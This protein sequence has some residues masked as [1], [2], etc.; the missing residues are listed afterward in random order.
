MHANR[1]KYSLLDYQEK[2]RNG[3]QRLGLICKNI[4]TNKRYI[5]RPV[6]SCP[7]LPEGRKKYF[8]KIYNR[9]KNLL[10]IKK[11][12][13]CTLTYS[14]SL[15]TPEAAALRI[16][17]D[18]DKFF[19][20]LE[21][22]KSKPQYFYVIEV[23]NNLMVHIHI[24]FQGYVHKSK[25]SASWKA[26]TGCTAIRIQGIDYQKALY[27]CF[28]YLTK[29][30]KQNQDKWA[31]IFK[32]IDRIW[33]CSRK[34]FG[35]ATPEAKKW[36]LECFFV[37][38]YQYSWA[39]FKDPS[40]DTKSRTISESESKDLISGFICDNCVISLSPQVSDCLVNPVPYERTMREK[41]DKQLLAFS[42]DG[43]EFSL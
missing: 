32:N 11:Y 1:I 37:D 33:S 36:I 40:I 14:T 42:K 28:K 27:Y 25:I 2:L 24:I 9:S 17:K 38:L 22:R 41:H 31:F 18:I 10:N 29:S 34:F 3:Y 26:V 7:W 43:W 13:F 21:Y 6:P 12:S 5:F 16:K 15:Y 20:R 30:K 19:K 39:F 23:T 8:S 4:E 35:K